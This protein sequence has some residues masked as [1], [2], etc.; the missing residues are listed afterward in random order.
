MDEKVGNYP[1]PR[2]DH[3]LQTQPTVSLAQTNFYPRSPRQSDF[4]VPQEKKQ[5]SSAGGAA[6]GVKPHGFNPQHKDTAVVGCYPP[7]SSCASCLCLQDG[8]VT[9]KEATTKS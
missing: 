3:V 4:G 6:D 9:W 1:H 5:F 7:Q 2:L 8:S